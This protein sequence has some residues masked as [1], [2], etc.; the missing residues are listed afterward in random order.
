MG[1]KQDESGTGEGVLT[2]VKLEKKSNTFINQAISCFSRNSPSLWL[3]I[4][5][6]NFWW[7]T[8]L[9]VSVADRLVSCQIWHD[10][11]WH[12]FL[13][14]GPCRSIESQQD[15]YGHQ[16]GRQWNWQGRSKGLVLGT[17]VCG[18][19][20]RNGE[21]EMDSSGVP[22]VFE[23]C[24]TLVLL[25]RCSAVGHVHLSKRVIEMGERIQ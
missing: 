24:E 22:V 20:P 5:A 12:S 9:Y 10:L 15:R 6:S 4:L 18:S 17:G 13:S 11:V 1:W 21:I 8:W 3:V 19:R 16:L 23:T 2:L 7:W 25:D 14:T